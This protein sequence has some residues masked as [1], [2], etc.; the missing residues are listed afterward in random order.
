MKKKLLIFLTAIRGRLSWDVV[1][2]KEK[3]ALVKKRATNDSAESTF[4]SFTE[5]L[6][7]YQMIDMFAASGTSD[8]RIN[9]YTR[10]PSTGKELKEKKIPG[11]MFQIPDN[12]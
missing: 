10:Q 11:L 6:N 5:M 7:N 12:L 2:D 8:I 9:G 4:S 1:T 3:H